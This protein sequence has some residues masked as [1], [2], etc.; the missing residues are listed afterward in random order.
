M[1]LEVNYKTWEQ[2][3]TLRN[4]VKPVRQFGWFS[5]KN[6][7]AIIPGVNKSSNEIY[8]VSA[9]YDSWWK[10]E[11]ANDNGASVAAILSVAKIMS[12]YTFEHTI[13]FVLTDGEEQ[14]LFGSNNYA[15]E[16]IEK[17][18]NIAGSI[19]LEVFGLAT[20]QEGSNKICVVERETSSWISDIIVNTSIKYNDQINLEVHPNRETKYGGDF[21]SFLDN[22][23]DSVTIYQ[24]EIDN[25]IHTFQ[26]THERLNM[27][28]LSKGTKLLLASVAEIAYDLQS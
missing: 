26:D 2:K 22:D 17:N 25:K 27:H 6:I 13:R 28:Y 20:T 16:A 15:V 19:F 11:G 23:I 21:L 8:V 5:G 10:S 9:H 18:E 7:E 4:L 1:G 14:G 12:Q 24:Y 3:P